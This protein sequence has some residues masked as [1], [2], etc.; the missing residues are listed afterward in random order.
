MYLCSGQITNR[1]Y[2]N[3]NKQRRSKR[4][5]QTSN[6]DMMDEQTILNNQIAIMKAL[7]DIK[8]VSKDNK[9]NLQDSIMFSK[10][11]LRALS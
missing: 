11:R 10:A 1:D 4:T 7:L 3:V 6:T 2:E 9:A 8:T 5:N